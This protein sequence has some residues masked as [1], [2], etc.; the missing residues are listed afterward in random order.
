MTW[1]LII[2]AFLLGVTFGV[3]VLALV[4]ILSEGQRA[5]DQEEKFWRRLERDDGEAE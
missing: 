2:G 3:V 1:L 5:S 4:A